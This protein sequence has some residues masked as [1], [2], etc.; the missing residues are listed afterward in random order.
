MPVL[1]VG[2]G[3]TVMLPFGYAH[4]VSVG[5]CTFTFI[6]LARFWANPSGSAPVEHDSSRMSV[7]GV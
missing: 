4:K 2:V 7:P 6:W 5:A 1:A 3:P